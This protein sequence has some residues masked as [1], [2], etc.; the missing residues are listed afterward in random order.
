[1]SQHQPRFLN[2]R[3]A[4]NFKVRS[5]TKPT[6]VT[7]KQRKKF[8]NGQR[9]LRSGAIQFQGKKGVWR[10]RKSGGCGCGR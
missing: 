8:T 2:P 5:S 7:Q 6:K 4:R 3:R 9:R 1:M 10:P